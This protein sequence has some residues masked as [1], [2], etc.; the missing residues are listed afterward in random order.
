MEKHGIFAPPTS[1]FWLLSSTS[2]SFIFC[3]V[4]MNSFQCRI[5]YGGVVLIHDTWDELCV[6]LRL[7]KSIL[8]TL[9]YILTTVLISRIQTVLAF[10]QKKGL[11]RHSGSQQW[12]CYIISA[13]SEKIEYQKGR[14]FDVLEINYFSGRWLLWLE[15][16]V[17]MM[18]R[19]ALVQTFTLNQ[20]GYDTLD[21]RGW[22]SVIFFCSIWSVRHILKN[23][24]HVA[25]IKLHLLWHL[26][27]F[28]DVYLYHCK[29]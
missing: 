4:V 19:G 7:G 21:V 13:H 10:Y 16:S 9:I 6:R 2:H 11:K 24:F 28:N 20:R 12:C 3:K 23:R 1:C 22:N 18:V 27:S 26:H 29:Q 14:I 8:K 5:I 17:F 25:L 15:L